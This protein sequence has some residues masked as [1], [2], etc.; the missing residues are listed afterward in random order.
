[1]T[2]L[3]EIFK[4]QG[5]LTEAQKAEFFTNLSEDTKQLIVETEDANFRKVLLSAMLDYTYT[6]DK[7]F[8]NK[9]VI[10]AALKEI[11]KEVN[12]QMKEQAK[13]YSK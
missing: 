6:L 13:T 2:T 8:C 4:T 9:P 7:E 12:K 1:M 11:L 10:K 5:E 3:N